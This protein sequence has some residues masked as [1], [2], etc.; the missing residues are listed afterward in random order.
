M[1]ARISTDAVHPI[2]ATV[3]RNSKSPNAKSRKINCLI[4]LHE[5]S[6]E[7]K[8][9]GIILIALVSI[10]CL[11]AGCGITLGSAKNEE[12]VTASED[13]TNINEVEYDV[14]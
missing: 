7:M 2:K 10:G 6:V 11:L 4:K 8:K 14:Y 12:T 5:E 1:S 13:T 3:R 9:R